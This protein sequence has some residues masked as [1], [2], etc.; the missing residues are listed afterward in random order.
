MRRRRFLATTLAAAL[1]GPQ[2]AGAQPGRKMTVGWLLPERKSFAL[3]PFRRRLQELGWSEGGNLT[4]EQRYAHGDRGRYV[5]I[6]ADL[7]KLRADVIVT[8]GS[9]ATAA[10]QRAT[11]TIPIVFVSGNPVAQGFVASL[12]HPGRNLTGV[13][14]LTGDLT[15]KRVQLLKEM[16][17][18]LARLAIVEDLTAA[19]L[20]IAPNDARLGGNWQAIETAAREAGVQLA[21]TVEIRTPAELDGAFSLA[22]REHANGV[23]VL[24]SPFFS[25][26]SRQLAAQAARARLPAIYE[27]RGF[28]EAGGLMS[29]GPDHRAMFRLVAEYVDRI[30]RGAKPEDLPVEQP[31]GLELV[32][33]ASTARTLGLAIPPS[34]LARA[35][36]IIQ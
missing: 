11:P 30:L 34:L 15:P 8:D 2:A 5:P 13:S 19:G 25:S 1:A 26:Q 22:V 35:D 32:I 27:H 10:A 3:D 33:N 9:A 23:L 4:I 7:V 16:V 17:T 24:A 28:V 14:I 6:A 36:G 18:G 21:P 31:T 29:Y 20:A 12:S